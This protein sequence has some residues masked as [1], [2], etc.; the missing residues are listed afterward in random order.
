MGLGVFPWAC[1]GFQI[2]SLDLVRISLFFYG[3]GVDFCVFPW[4]SCGFQYCSIDLVC[5]SEFFLDVAWNSLFFQDLAWNSV[6]FF[7]G[8]VWISCLFVRFEVNLV[9]F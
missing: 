8:V 2:C 3:F 6:F 5:I 4:I 1:C 7:G 9:V